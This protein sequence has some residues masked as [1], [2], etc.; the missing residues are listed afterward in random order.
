MSLVGLR[1]RHHPALSGIVTTSEVRD[2]RIHLKM[3]SGDYLTFSIKAAQS[4]GSPYCVS[5]SP[6]VP[7]K[8]DIVHILAICETY[9]DIRKRILP[10][11]QKSQSNID[12]QDVCSQD[13][14]F[15]QLIVDPSSFNLDVR[16]NI[17][18]PILPS[19]SK[20]SRDYC[21]AIHTK[22]MINLKARD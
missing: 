10:G 2:A 6:K 3:L 8:E 20:L 7:Q 15:T 1:G 14:S 13:K 21:N 12:F 4:G 17:S 5:C 18:D 22:R 11:F 9:T 19:I 16:I